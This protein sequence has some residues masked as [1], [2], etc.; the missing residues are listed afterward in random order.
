[1]AAALTLAAAPNPVLPERVAPI[2]KTTTI[3]GDP[4]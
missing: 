4:A 3:G 2:G 1:M